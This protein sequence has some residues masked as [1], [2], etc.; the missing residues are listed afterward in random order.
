MYWFGIHSFAFAEFLDKIFVLPFTYGWIW[1][2]HLVWYCDT[3]TIQLV[4]RESL[5]FPGLSNGD[6]NG[7]LLFGYPKDPA[8]K[9]QV[10]AL[11][12]ACSTIGFCLLKILYY[13]QSLVPIIVKSS[14][15]Y[16]WFQNLLLIYWIN[17]IIN[18]NQAKSIE[19]RVGPLH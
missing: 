18:S 8:R 11:S 7:P 9:I 13:H 1:H 2:E 14:E 19:V 12:Q 6:V 15:F 5:G 10:C 16:M 3:N 4:Y 17:I